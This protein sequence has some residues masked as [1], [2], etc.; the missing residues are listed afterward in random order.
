MK[1]DYKFGVDS[2]QLILRVLFCYVL[3]S[4]GRFGLFTITYALKA[5]L[6]NTG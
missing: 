4:L 6:G 2:H 1:G 5:L 3:H